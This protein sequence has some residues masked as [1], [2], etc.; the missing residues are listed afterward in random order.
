[1]ALVHSEDTSIE[2]AVRKTLHS[3]GFRYR[4]HRKDLPGRPDIVLPRYSTVVFVHGCFWH[5]HEC[6]RFRLPVSNRSYWIAKIARN[7]KRDVVN[8]A[9]LR[10]RNWKVCVIWECDLNAGMVA[11]ITRLRNPGGDPSRLAKR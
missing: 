2:L 10:E 8:F 9:A 5:G 4:L 7:V 11:L 1:M 3:A 6:R